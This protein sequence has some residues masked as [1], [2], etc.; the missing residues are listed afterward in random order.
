MSKQAQQINRNKLKEKKTVDK[1]II[2]ED[3]TLN[4]EIFWCL[5]IVLT[6]ESYNLCS[7]LVPLFQRV[8]AGHEVTGHFVLG[9]TKSRYTM[10]YGIAPELKKMLYYYVNQ[11]P[12]F[13]ISYDESLNSELQ[14]CQMDVVL[15][16][17]NEKNGQV[18]TKYFDS[19]FP[20]C[21]NGCQ[22][23]VVLRFWNEKNGQVETKYF[24]SQF[25]ACPN[26]EN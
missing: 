9:K 4:A 22:M 23:D 18:E 25:P 2:N 1:L 15:R 10:L 16:F 24:D 5:R 11:S 8:F 7:Y 20:A 3:N 26:A 17:W 6:H 21:P 13:S 12:Y 19:Q 14:M